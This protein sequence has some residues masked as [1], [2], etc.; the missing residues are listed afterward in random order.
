M[1][2]QVCPFTVCTVALPGLVCIFLSSPRSSVSTLSQSTS[3]SSL[4]CAILNQLRS[5]CSITWVLSFI[6]WDCLCRFPNSLQNAF[7]FKTLS[8]CLYSALQA[9]LALA[10]NWPT[11]PCGFPPSLPVDTPQRL[12]TR[13]SSSWGHKGKKS[14]V[15]WP[16]GNEVKTMT[17]IKETE[18]RSIFRGENKTHSA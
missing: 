11:W 18:H 5:L 1:K 16:K 4:N 14:K 12:L 3:F 8:N 10:A 6:Q 2:Q 7:K 15:C 17:V 13:G 9:H